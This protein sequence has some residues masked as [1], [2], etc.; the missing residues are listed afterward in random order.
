MSLPNG[1]RSALLVVAVLLAL[2]GG[3]ALG[4]T[5]GER[6]SRPGHDELVIEDPALATGGTPSATLQRLHADIV[7]TL[8]LPDVRERLAKDGSEAVGSAPDRFS[9]FIVA[10]IERARGV[11]QKA[12]MRAD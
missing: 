9:A 1:V 3:T 7:R 6:T 2:G 5:L 12:R 8:A 10:E 4:M 11:A